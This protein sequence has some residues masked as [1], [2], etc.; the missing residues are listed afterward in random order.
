MY[1]ACYGGQ[2]GCKPVEGLDLE[3]RCKVNGF[4]FLGVRCLG[5]AEVSAGVRDCVVE[6]WSIRSEL[7]FQMVPCHGY[8]A[9][10]TKG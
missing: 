4:H 9:A 5:S 8:C 10:F 2:V 7:T 6:C 1:N 3:V